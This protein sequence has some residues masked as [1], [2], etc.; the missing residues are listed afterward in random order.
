MKTAPKKKLEERPL[1]G[2]PEGIMPMLCTLL[3]EPFSNPDYLFEIKWDGYRLIGYKNKN[4][5]RLSS[6]RGV[7]YTRKYPPI[8]QAIQGLPHEVVLDGEAVVLDKEGKPDFDALQNFNG[9]KSGVLYYVFDILWLDGKELMHLPLLERKDILNK[10]IAGN[11]IIRFSDHFE[12]GMELFQQA[13]SMGLE[14]IIAKQK[15]SPYVPGERGREWYKIPSE[16]R[17]EF[18]I[19]GWVE[20]ESRL[21]RTL[22]FGAYQG[23]YLHWIG[24]AGGGFK[25]REMGAILVR[26][27][28]LETAKSPFANEVAYEGVVH[29]VKPELVVNIKYAAMTKAGK[30]RKPA[31]F[32][33]FRE[34]KRPKDVVWERVERPPSSRENSKQTASSKLPLTKKNS[35]TSTSADSNWPLV[36]SEKIV[37]EEVLDLNPCPIRVYNVDRELWRGITKAHLI[38]YYHTVSPYLLPHVKDRPLSLHL[39]LKGPNAPGAYIKDMEGRQPECAGIF[40]TERKHPKAGKRSVIDYLVCNNV[41]TL[42]H[43]INIGCIDVNPWTS[44]ITSPVTPDFIVIDLDPS[45]KNFLKVIETALAAKDFFDEYKLVSFPK[46][47]GKTGMHLYL[48]C[49]AFSFPQAR[50]IAENICSEIHLRVPEITTTAVRVAD[51]GSNLY[52]DPNQNDYADTV[53]AAYSVRPYKKPTVSTPLAWE[54][55]NRTLDPA[56]FTIDA[57]EKRLRE[58]GDLFE[59]VLKKETALTNDTVLKK[60]V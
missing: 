48:P 57:I 11:K 43:T 16:V 4:L 3:R 24:H 38:H 18:V 9:Q 60:F 32:L 19:G 58:K 36:E 14:G 10:I 28:S 54:E 50:N 25:E 29:W 23:E 59:G 45:D 31:I 34:D 51:R 17:Q 33:G 55:V 52:L 49:S 35:K 22:L 12:N 44:S 39:K 20:S 1:V 2:M 30:I 40:T 42:I 41:A 5:V 15:N 26:L 21:F 53:A 13:R 6:R 56:A 27:K 46:T 37:R 8:V 47:S 7:D